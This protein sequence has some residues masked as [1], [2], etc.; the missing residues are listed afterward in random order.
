[1][2]QL[3]GQHGAV[4]GFVVQLHALQEVLD[5]AVVLGFLGF[6]VDGQEF[7]HLELLLSCLYRRTENQSD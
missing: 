4:L 7:L 1:M 3:S 6:A 2:V 5:R